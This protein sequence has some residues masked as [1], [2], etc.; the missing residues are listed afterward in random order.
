MNNERKTDSQLISDA[1]AGK[2][3]SKDDLIRRYL[4]LV[5]WH[6]RR[7]ERADMPFEDCRQEALIGLV[8]AIDSYNPHASAQ[9]KTYATRCI[10]N[11][12]ISHQRAVARSVPTVEIPHEH[13]ELG[14][15]ENLATSDGGEETGAHADLE[16]LLK[17]MSRVLSKREFEIM[18]LRAQEYST[19]EIAE[20]CG[21][22]SKQ[23]ANALARARKKLKSY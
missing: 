1:A 14:G 23:V 3:E 5:D 16:D 2:Q 10:T 13:E 9:F 6:A 20:K 22:T 18:T 7:F 15:I 8:R 21:L 19:E 17:Y 4:P 11:A 12:L